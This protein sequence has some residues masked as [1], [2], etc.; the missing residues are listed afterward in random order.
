VA[1]SGLDSIVERE[2]LAREATLNLHLLKDVTDDCFEALKKPL[3]K[4]GKAGRWRSP[5]DLHVCRSSARR[6][7]RK[8]GRSTFATRSKA[9]GRQSRTRPR[10]RSIA[11]ASFSNM[12]QRLAWT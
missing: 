1:A 4:E 8:S 5:L 3:K 9:F 12:P 10:R 11:S 7:L 2:R 6:L